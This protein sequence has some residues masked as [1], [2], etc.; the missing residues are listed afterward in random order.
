MSRCVFFT[1]FGLL[2]LTI[3]LTAISCARTPPADLPPLPHSADASPISYA[4]QVQPVLENRCVVCHGCYDAPCQLQ[5]SSFAGLDRGASKD[6]VYHSTRFVESGPSRLGIDAR[7]TPEWRERGFFSVVEPVSTAEAYP[8]L[9]GMLALGRMHSFTP[10]ELLPDSVGLDVSRKLTCPA[11]DEFGDYVKQHPLGGMPYGT[12]PL[13][14]AEIGVIAS[15]VAQ[16]ASAPPARPALPAE[17]QVQMESWEEFLNGDSLKQRITARYLFEHWFLAHLYFENL[18]SGPFFRVVRSRTAPRSPVDE[19]A[20]RRPY[21][22][23]GDEPFWYRLTPIETAVVRK[24][25]IIY[26]LSPARMERLM[27]LFLESS[28]Q[29]TRLPSY[30]T[31]QA[32]NPFSSFDQIPARSRYQY[33]LDDAQYFISSF[34]RGPVCRGQVAVDVIRDHF[35]VA[36]VDPDHDLSSV[37]PSFLERAKEFLNLPAE[38]GS[39]LA[40]G[41]LWLEYAHQQKRYLEVLEEY[42]DRADPQGLGPTLDAIWDGDGHNTNALLTVFRNFDNAMVVRG[43]HGEIPKTAWVMDFPILERLYYD[44][45]A[46]FDVFGSLTHQLSTRLYMDHLRMQSENLFLAFLP[47]AERA[48]L[49]ASWYIGATKSRD[50]HQV[51]YMRSNGHGSQVSFSS[52]DKKRELIEMFLA[53]NPSVSGAPDV[54]NRCPIKPCDRPE[55][56]AVERRIERALQTLTGVHGPW[57][58]QLPELTLLRVRA[59]ANSGGTATYT[60]VHNRAHTNVASAFAEKD[61]LIPED[62]TLTV[63]RGTVGSYPNF[64]LDLA[65][66]DI[67]SFTKTLKSVNDGASLTKL[68]DRWGV[69]RTSPHFWETMD[70]IRADSRRQNPTEAGILDLNRYQNL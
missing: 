43:F 23:P 49:R 22:S 57:V 35:F 5:L 24:T 54:L 39:H 26:P 2:L 47:E 30:E 48:P 11:A 44:L 17:A 18:P 9:L 46:G 62:D 65:L 42:Y 58:A 56:T 61:R 3:A 15:W 70:S 38:H 41:G 27:E 13:R 19:I 55:A 60:L 67:E 51:D 28:W 66:T 53:R 1:G 45:V 12:A 6:A 68:V 10:D 31:S 52:A 4:E 29:P 16:G 37:D 50:Y 40:P 64:V 14:D 33:L 32:S 20:T 36:F 59:P 34:I 8:L 7:S 69:R 21:D 63:L 25:H